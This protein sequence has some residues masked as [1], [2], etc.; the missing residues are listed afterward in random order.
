[1]ALDGGARPEPPRL[2]GRRR[3]AGLT[4]AARAW[5]TSTRLSSQ[6]DGGRQGSVAA[7]RGRRRAD[8]AAGLG[9]G[10]PTGPARYRDMV[11]TL[12]VGAGPG[13]PLRACG[14]PGL[15]RAARSPRS[16]RFLDHDRR[17]RTLTGVV[18][19]EAHDEVGRMAQAVNPGRRRKH[20]GPRSVRLGHRGADTLAGRSTELSKGQRAGSPTNARA[21]PP[22][23][24]DQVAATPPGRSRHNVNTVSAG[25]EEMGSSIREIA[26]Q[27]ERGR[28]GG[29]RRA[30]TVWRKTNA[31]V[32]QAWAR[33]S[34]EIGSVIKVITSIAEQTKPCWALNATIEGGPGRV[35][36]GKGLRGGRRRGPR[37]LAQEDGRGPDP[38]TS[39]GRVGGD[40]G[41]TPRERG[42]RGSRKSVQSSQRSMT[43]R[44]TIASGRRGAGPAGPTQGDEPQRP[45]TPAGGRREHPPGNIFGD[46]PPPPATNRPRFVSKQPAH[47][48]RTRRPSRP[49]CTELVLPVSGN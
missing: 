27:R 8:Q 43:I 13:L 16:L 45:R 34:A 14:C 4:V 28:E 20:P 46:G 40:P 21:G 23:Q 31:T 32:G 36:A 44:V 10:P 47:R 30:V 2:P 19:V 11:V 42:V 49:S 38:R 6:P 3:P 37:I 22:R 26:Q 39:P 9:H 12:V 33:S 48:R 18:E 1:V 15:D 41:P 24:A 35:D 25:S 29:P 5:P 7:N 17:R